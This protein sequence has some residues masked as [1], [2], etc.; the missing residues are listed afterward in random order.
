MLPCDGVGVCKVPESLTE[1]RV[2]AM[3]AA[4]FQSSARTGAHPRS[5]PLLNSSSSILLLLLTRQS[6]GFFEGFSEMFGMV[7]RGDPFY[8]VVATKES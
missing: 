2:G 7:G 8:A 5:H 3:K 6:A 1:R 4:P